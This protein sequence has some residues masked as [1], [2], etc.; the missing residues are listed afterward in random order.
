MDSDLAS[1]IYSQAS[2]ARVAVQV[3]F[4]RWGHR[5]ISDRLWAGLR[6]PGHRAL[7]SHQYVGRILGALQRCNTL[8][9]P[10]LRA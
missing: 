2:M 8:H 10:R 9:Q 3:N 7:S 5:S 6:L 4:V 1:D